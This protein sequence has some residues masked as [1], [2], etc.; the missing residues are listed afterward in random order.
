MELYFQLFYEFAKTGLFAIGGGL[1]TLPFLYEIGKKTGWYT[2]EDVS[3]MIAISQSTPGPIGVNMATYVGF[4]LAGILGGIFTTVS[5]VLPSVVIII[6]ISKALNKFKESELV[7]KIFFGIRPAST[8]LILSSG[9]QV[10]LISM[11]DIKSYEQTKNILKV[12]QYKS[13]LLGI[14]IFVIMKFT[15]LHPIFLIAISAVVGVIFKF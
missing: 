14:I 3:D 10:A 1:A 5:L 9:I 13:I 8:A 11:F 2:T 15:K 12:L 4:S 7:E 6:A